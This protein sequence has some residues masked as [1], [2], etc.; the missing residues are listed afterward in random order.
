MP[1]PLTLHQRGQQ[2]YW[3]RPLQLVYGPERIEDNWWRDAV[4]RDYYVATDER[5]WLYWVFCARLTRQWYLHGVFA[6]HPSL[7]QHDLFKARQGNKL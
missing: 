3:H 2:L 5:G 6:C 1:Q 4:S 7:K